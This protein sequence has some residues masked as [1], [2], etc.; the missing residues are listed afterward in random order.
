MFK[1]RKKFWLQSKNSL[2]R[3]CLCAILALLTTLS[4]PAWSIPNLPLSSQVVTQTNNDGQFLLEQGIVYYQGGN[5][6]EASE[7]WQRALK[8]FIANGE[9][10][11]QALVLSNLSIAYQYL[12][13]LEDAEN[14]I[15]QSINLLKTIPLETNQQTYAEVYAKA[16]NTQARLQWLTG[17]LEAAFTTWQ[18]A[19]IQ[20]HQANHESGR[21]GSLINQAQALQGMGLHLQAEEKLQAINL[22]LEQQSDVSLQATGWLNLGKVLRKIGKLT[23]PNN[24]QQDEPDGSLQVLA[25]SLAAAQLAKNQNLEISALIELGNTQRALADRASIMEQIEDVQTYHQQA[26]NSY[27]Q[28]AQIPS[29]LKLK[30]QL[31]WLS[32]PVKQ[33]YPQLLA[34]VNSIQDQITQ[35]PVSRTA[36]FEQLNLARSL[37]CLQ[38]QLNRDNPWCA[39]ERF[40]EYD[41]L[42]DWSE[43][44]QLIAQA[45]Q[46]AREIQ[47]IQAESYGLGQ[48]GG[49]YEL[50]GQWQDA[51]QLTQ[52]A[53]T[54]IE[55]QKPQFAQTNTNRPPSPDLLYRWQWQLGRLLKRQGNEQGAIAAYQAAVIAL[56]SVTLDLIYVDSDLL[57]SFQENIE[58]LY[59]ELL[60]LLLPEKPG[61]GEG[62]SFRIAQAREN[63]K[64]LQKSELESFLRCSLQ[65]I[66][67]RQVDNLIDRD[68]STEAVIYPILLKQRIGIILRLPN[69]QELKPYSS[70]LQDVDIQKI[71]TEIEQELRFAGSRNKVKQLAKKLYPLLIPPE[72]EKDLEAHNVDTLV[73][74]LDAPFRNIPMSVLYDG[75]QYLIEKYAVGVTSGLELIESQSLTR[76][77]LQAALAGLTQSRL[78]YSPLKNNQQQL[79]QIQSQIPGEMILDENFTV[80]G[81]QN[82]LNSLPF[83]V[84]HIATH[85]QFS[86]QP[87]ETF[88]VAWNDKIRLNNL[89][90]LLRNRAQTRPE[91]VELL[92]LAACETSQGDK[93]A[94]LGLAGI[95]VNSG[96]RSTLAT[97]WKTSADESSGAFFSTFYQQLRDEPQITKAQ[98]LR[99]AQLKFL[100]DKEW[101][102]PYYWAPYVLIGNWL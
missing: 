27:Q 6:T 16:L 5:Y 21:I 31:N 42:V 11:K 25:K 77:N 89:R 81:F 57:F 17:K 41:Q 8:A 64:L 3:A 37:T 90:D 76:G 84:V 100:Q 40:P 91:P 86:S 29:P 7:I 24:P 65:D 26:L 44:A 62:E 58:P 78:G 83:P 15:A 19:A 51:Q 95:A 22:K 36:I 54:I 23:Q 99:Q 10:L 1:Q 4:I 53:I 61:T 52:Q 63:I 46:Q 43:I 102:A 73:F 39:G 67:Q 56:N 79:E 38:T 34:L 49:L 96:A 28:A 82:L 59:R 2:I 18:Q 68:N 48:L 94:A 30:A 74:L 71:L 20:Y 69:S 47:D 66:Q 9:E 13:Q 72:L 97:L 93:R 55:T 45:V 32:L 101:K 92:V 33:D 88:L 50:Q 35:L 87:E 12:G 98:A 75:E 70:S 60:D 80:E 14:A 85:G